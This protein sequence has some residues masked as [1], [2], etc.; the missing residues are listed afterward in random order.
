ME[1]PDQS[2]NLRDDTSRDIL[3]VTLRQVVAATRVHSEAPFKIDGA[4]VHEVIT[5]AH[6]VRVRAYDSITF[7]DLEDGTTGGRVA[8]KRWRNNRETEGIP[9]DGRPFYAQI[10]GKIVRGAQETRNVLEINQLGGLHEVTDP[11]HVLLHILEVA[12]FTLMLKHGSPSDVVRRSVG[13]RASEGGGVKA[14][15]GSSA[16]STPVVARTIRSEPCSPP[17]T[18]VPRPQFESP[19]PHSRP[20]TPPRPQSRAATEPPTSPTPA[21]TPR[22]RD[23]TP[24]PVDPASVGHELV[25][26]VQASNSRRASGLRRDP[27]GHL[28]VLQRAIILLILNAS[29][30]TATTSAEGVSVIAI[31][32]GVAHHEVTCVQIGDALDE[33]TERGYIVPTDSESK[34]Y[35]IKTNHYPMPK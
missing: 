27:Y 5:V 9:T 24:T 20:A 22:T 28:T 34:H 25:A 23:S 33:L 29:T 21:S 17:D 2:R 30:A 15:M 3:P 26:Q 32:H 18:Y 8:A 16:P 35:T 1:D 19:A 4:P 10:I 11:H 6:V 13:P 12:Y 14:E 31:V 7:F